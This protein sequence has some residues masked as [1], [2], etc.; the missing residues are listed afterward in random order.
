MEVSRAFPLPFLESPPHSVIYQGDAFKVLQKFPDGAI[1]MGVTSPS[2]WGLRDYDVPGQ[3]GSEENVDDYVINLVKILREVKRVLKNDGIFWLN[4]GD[5][6]T[7]G[8]RTWRAPDPKNPNRAMSYRAP[9]PE[10]LKP[11]ELVGVPWRVASALQ[12]DGWYIRSEIIWNKPNVHPESVKDRPTRSHEFIF[13]ITKSEQYYYDYESIREVG[14]NGKPRNKR[15][16]WD[17]NTKPSGT[18]HPATFPDDLIVPCILAGSKEGDVILDPFIGS[19]TTGLVAR[20]HN[21]IFVG[22]EIK[23][24]Y[25]NEARERLR[26]SGIRFDTIES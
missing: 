16:V 9:T 21:R 25:I 4:I 3:L 2:Y 14:L 8:G 5:S 6:Y 10:G 11:K 13:L 7:S 24:D 26:K 22:I 18:N 1:Q 12:A 15:T 17:V 20:R 23:L 19:G